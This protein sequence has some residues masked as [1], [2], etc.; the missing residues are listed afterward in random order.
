MSQSG[1]AGPASDPAIT[2]GRVKH[3]H[4]ETECH[5]LGAE[6][7]AED[8]S[9]SI[10]SLPSSI[11]HASKKVKAM[12]QVR[13]KDY[14]GPKQ[15]MTAFLL[16]KRLE[17]EMTTMMKLMMVPL[18]IQIRTK[19]P[20]PK[21]KLVSLNKWKRLIWVQLIL[22]SDNKLAQLWKAAIYAFFTPLP[23]IKFCGTLIQ[24]MPAP[25]VLYDDTFTSV[26]ETMFSII[27]KELSKHKPKNRSIVS[28][29]KRFGSKIISY[30]IWPHTKMEVRSHPFNL[31]ANHGFKCLMKMG[32]PEHYI[33]H[34]MTV[35]HD[36]KTIFA[37]T[38]N[39]I[40]KY[41]RMLD[42]LLSFAT[43]AWMSPNHCAYVALIAHFV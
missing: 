25:L 30:S 35:S 23:D 42:G 16:W 14:P 9:S 24:L 34:P 2:D 32:H 17:L 21:L 10:I 11:R 27:D 31:F 12:I 15:I 39:Q 43:D 36:M 26:G 7:A 4:K 3:K 18:P 8:S 22:C 20:I 6:Q 5:H 37:K 29:L 13:A 40:S 1:D 19:I 38:C 33:P 28:M 41:L